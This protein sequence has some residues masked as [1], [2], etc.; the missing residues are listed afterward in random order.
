L[1]ALVRDGLLIRKRALRSRAREHASRL[2]L[3]ARRSTRARVGAVVV[4]CSTDLDELATLCDRVFVLHHGRVCA[5]LPGKSL[6][7]LHILAA[8]NTGTLPAA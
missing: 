1:V 4:L 7:Q 3:R 6:R 2:N 8:T 5:Q